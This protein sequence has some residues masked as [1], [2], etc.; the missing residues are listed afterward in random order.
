MSSDGFD[1]AD[2]LGRVREHDQLAA[3]TLVERLYPGV[4]RI[5]RA[6]LPRRDAEEDLVQ[7]IF[8]KMFARLDQYHG[9]VPLEH[10]VSRIAV[11]TCYDRLRAQQRRP[12][13][14]QADL[15]EAEAERLERSAVVSED[16]DV[17]D[18]IGARETVEQLLA[19]LCPSDRLLI[20]LLELEERSIAEIR[21]ITGWNAALIK[22]RAFRARQKLR[23]E[24]E[25]RQRMESSR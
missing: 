21:A 23:K 7:E 9:N 3:R 22:V 13:L 12:E 20:T 11:R 1:E 16:P 25:R 18:A 6:H 19:K 24:W 10:W 17:A 15:S 2:C 5:V 8:M 14:R 4:I